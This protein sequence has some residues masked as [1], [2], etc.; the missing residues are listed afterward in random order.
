MMKLRLAEN[1]RRKSVLETQNQCFKELFSSIALIPPGIVS[2][3]GLMMLG[4]VGLKRH[5]VIAGSASQRF[6]SSLHSRRLVR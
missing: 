2:L 1:Y 4:G 6:A 5:G 3:S